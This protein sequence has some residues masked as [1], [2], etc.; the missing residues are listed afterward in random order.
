MEMSDYTLLFVDDESAILRSLKRTF[1]DNYEIFL[2]ESGEEALKILERVHVHLVVSDY[3]MPGM[4]GLQLL[5]TIQEKWPETI[6]VMLTGVAD[7]NSVTNDIDSGAIYRF[8]SKPWEDEEIKQAVRLALQQYD[9]IQK[10]KKLKQDKGVQQQDVEVTI[11][12]QKGADD[13]VFT[14]LFVDDEEIVLG[15]L[16]RIFTD[17]N[18]RIVTAENAEE[19]LAIL[20][21]EPVHLIVSDYKMPGMTGLQFLREVKKRWPQTIRVMLTGYADIKGV[22]GDISEGVIYKFIAKPWENE[23]LKMAV[24]LALR[25]YALISQAKRLQESN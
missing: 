9:L 23:D 21:K 3:R 24:K 12:E 4:D 15:A 19:G 2:A 16:K 22:M 20:E 8:I 11:P 25:Q 7:V 13:G 1:Q 18:Y 5:K 14:L 6:R 17:E 10:I